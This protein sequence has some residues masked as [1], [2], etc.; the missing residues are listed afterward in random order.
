[1]VNVVGGG[2]TPQVQQQPDVDG[3]A[4]VEGGVGG[5]AAGKGVAGDDGLVIENADDAPGVGA[6]GPTHEIDAPKP[7]ADANM[8]TPMQDMNHEGWLDFKA[9]WL[10]IHIAGFDTMRELNEIQEKAS[11][12]EV[13]ELKDY[14]K[15]QD[16]LADDTKESETNKGW[17]QIAAGTAG[18]VGGLGGVYAGSSNAALGQAFSGVGSS[19]G[20]LGTAIETEWDA[21]L[22]GQLK[23]DEKES[24]VAQTA[25][26]KSGDLWQKYGSA[27][28]KTL[29]TDSEVRRSQA[30][31]YNAQTSALKA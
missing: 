12:N 25:M 24:T 17:A 11:E 2:T 16:D 9:I 8:P 31:M 26:Q 21:G 19:A 28:A 29:D 10:M 27:F 14:I 3:K 15:A 30:D 5:V 13:M 23:T 20:G 22:Q 4:K 7:G 18:I 1:M 6:P